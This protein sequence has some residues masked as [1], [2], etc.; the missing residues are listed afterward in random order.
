MRAYLTILGGLFAIL[1]TFNS[2]K[3][4]DNY[5]GL[6]I[7]T[8][9]DFIQMLQY[10]SVEIDVLLNDLNVP[11]DHILTVENSPNASIEVHQNGSIGDPQNVR[12]MYTPNSNFTGTDTFNYT[13][14]DASATSC[15]T[16]T[17]T[18]EVL[19]ASPVN[20]EIEE[21]PYP[22]LSDYNFFT[23]TMS[24]LI[25]VYGVVPFEPISAL[26]SDYALKKRFLWMPGDVKAR[27][28]SDHEVLD[29][30]NGAVLIKNFYYENVQPGNT[31]VLIET[32]L[33]IKKQEG[34]IFANYIWNESQTE[35]FYDLSGGFKNLSWLENGELKTVEYRIPAESQ[36]FTCHK[37]EINSTPIGI[38]PQNINNQY[39]YD[40]GSENQLQ[41]L[42]QMGYLEDNIPA[43]INTVVDWQDTSKSLDLRVRSYFDVNCAH[44]HSDVKHCDYR[45]VRFAFNESGDPANLGVCIEPDTN[46]PP[47][48]HI[49]NAGDP[50]TSVLFFRFSTT[51]EQYRMPLFGR[52]LVHEEAVEL[53][54]AWINSL[55]TN[56][57]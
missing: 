20:F 33:M 14:C 1:F 21:V 57:D 51:E 19:P 53:V 52:T 27:Y 48:T 45:P 37:A 54:A 55:S 41:H 44:C 16:E 10:E 6:A 2:C 47:Y 32:R 39:I 7:E 9:A 38:K 42:V 56:C 8:E 40:F 23:G 30:P 18:V 26:F 3:E 22:K 5:T 43:T 11:D 50:D 36:C 29:L 13:V 4:D 25:P 34:W 24:D 28:V 46:I 17:V 31:K 35:A 12:I 15:A 49:V